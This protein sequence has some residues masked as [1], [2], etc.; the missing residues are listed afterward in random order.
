MPQAR[1]PDFY[2][3]SSPGQVGALPPSCGGGHGARGRCRHLVVAAPWRAGA[4]C[5]HLVVGAPGAPGQGALPPSRG[6]GPAG[7]PLAALLPF[8]HRPE[9]VPASSAPS[10]LRAACAGR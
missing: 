8:L 2:E 7:R 4:R 6:G 10:R 5:R 9:A 3:G 1:C